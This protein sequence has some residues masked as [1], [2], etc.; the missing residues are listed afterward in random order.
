MVVAPR[1]HQQPEGQKMRRPTIV[2]PLLAILL[3]AGSTLTASQVS[4]LTGRASIVLG[5]RYLLRANLDFAA[6]TISARERITI[7]NKS[8]VTISKVNLSVTPRAFRELTSIGGFNVDGRTVSARWTN[9][10]NLELQLGRN[11]PTGSKAVIRLRFAVRASNVIGTSLEG[12]LSKANR[13]M[14]VGHWF[15]IVSDG[16]ATRYPGDAQ[17]TRAASLIRLELTTNSSTVRI[18]APG[19][20]VQRIGRYHVYELTHARDFAFGASPD[21]RLATGDAAGVRIEAWSTTGVGAL[22]VASAM[23][24]LNRFESAY[25]QYGWSRFV[26]VQ[27]GRPGSGNEYPGLVFLG[28]RLFAEREV[29]AHE[30]AHQWWYAM[31]GNDQM[32]EPW[33]DEGIAEFSARH[34][35]GEHP[36]YVSDRPVNSR[37]HDFPNIPAPQTSGDADSYDQTVYFKGAAFLETLHAEMG[38]DAFFAGMRALFAANRNGVITTAK[39]VETMAAHGASRTTMA[40]FLSL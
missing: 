33:L 17:H 36:D 30:T 12:R 25:G 35:F 28:G 7:T 32:R 18:A 22:A 2:A 24:A 34:F 29:V 6:G 38:S 8:G 39:F 19:R 1:P 11:L 27:S 15:P 10:S 40:T 37:I 21:Y 3:L 5:T 13:I 31:A 14:Q 26:I 4:A 16:H 20:L 9:N 23:A